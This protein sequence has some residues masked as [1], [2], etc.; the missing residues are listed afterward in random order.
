[1]PREKWEVRYD[2]NVANEIVEALDIG[3]LSRDDIKVLKRWVSE[4]ESRGLSYAQANRDWRDHELTRGRWKDHRAISFSFSGRLIYR[5][6]D[7]KLFVM[8]VRVSPNHDYR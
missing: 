3:I 5:T 7:L 1:M 2:T 6:E 8:V 4:V